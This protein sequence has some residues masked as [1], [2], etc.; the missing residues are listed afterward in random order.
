[1]FKAFELITSEFDYVK[2]TTYEVTITVQFHRTKKSEKY[3]MYLQNVHP[4]RNILEA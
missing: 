3:N 1:M 4:R 2:V